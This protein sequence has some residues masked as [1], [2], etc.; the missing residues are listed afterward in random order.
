MAGKTIYEK[1]WDAHVIVQR[2]DGQCLMYV[3]RHMIHDGGFHSFGMLRESGRKVRKTAQT[4]G[5]PDHY[6]STTVRSIAEMDDEEAIEKV[7]GLAINARDFGINH[8]AIDDERMGISHVIGPE[9]GITQPG[10]LLCCGDSHTSTHGAM[11]CISFGIGAS[12]ATHVLATQTIWQKKPKL[13]RINVEG[14]L[15]FSVTGKDVALALIAQETAACGVGHALEY[16]GPC[17]KQLDMEGRL[18]LSNMTIEA[19]SRTGLIAP[20]EKTFAFIEGKEFAPKGEKWE[21]AM[22][23]WQT[24]PTDED[25]EFDA[26]V[27]LDGSAI[28]PMVTWGTSPQHAIRITDPVPDPD[29]EADTEKRAAMKRALEYA[30]LK[31]G[32]MMTD[33]PVDRVFIGSCTNSRLQDLRLAAEVVKGKKVKCW[34]MISPGSGTVRKQAE[35]EGLDKIFTDAGFEWRYSG[36]SMC[37]G[38]N[39]D[40]LDTG[41]RSASTSNRNFEGRQG[42]GTRT[43]LVSPAMAAAAA[44]TGK[45]TDVRTLME[46]K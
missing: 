29:K 39:G 45:F 23:H 38:L 9:L 21:R 35:A 17:I 46:E 1:I 32:Q 33:V 7:E 13:M 25:A 2:D 19:G 27:T 5:S 42:P 31:P 16:A 28:A 36:C 22:A 40:L 18:T 30:G 43:H 4:F 26:E 20:D 6:A 15:G 41:E 8:F 10:I 44:V 11:G 14:K 34:S 37:V 24:L 3:D 12:E